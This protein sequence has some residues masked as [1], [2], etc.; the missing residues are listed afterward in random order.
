[1]KKEILFIWF[2]DNIPQYCNWTLNNY[3]KINDDWEIKFIHY[4][5][6]QI[7][8]SKKI[9]DNIFQKSYNLFLQKNADK[10]NFIEYKNSFSY[11]VDI[12]KIE[13]I[14]N[15]NYP[16]IY[17]DLDTFPICKF[18]DFFNIN[19]Y[20]K[21]CQYHSYSY[22]NDQNNNFFWHIDM[23]FLSNIFD[24]KHK[25][26]E[27]DKNINLKEK[28]ISYESFILND[29]KK[30]LLSLKQR[31]IDFYNC[32]LDLNNSFCCTEFTPIEHYFQRERYKLE[33][34]CNKI[35]I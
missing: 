10:S 21:N 11:L 32:S 23:W 12:Y 35:I 31:F 3:K 2:G 5:K 15:A 1:M 27:I 13:Y 34:A 28:I 6:D 29:N 30:Q 18:N 25:L 19:S 24:T 8:N 17:C 4:T 33:N 26:L 9:N 14:W 20:I 16:V 22:Y 7:L